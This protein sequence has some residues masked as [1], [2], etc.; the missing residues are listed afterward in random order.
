[1]DKIINKLLVFLLLMA[2]ATPIFSQDSRSYVKQC[3]K[4]HGQCKAVAIT[5]NFGDVVLYGKNGWACKN[6]PVEL[7]DALK[8]LSER[9]STINDVQLTEKGH[10]LVIFD[11]NGYKHSAG[12]PTAFISKLREFNLNHETIISA[13]FNDEGEWAAITQ[14]HLSAS[15][16][17]LLSWLQDGISSYGRIIS[18]TIVDNAVVAVY[19]GGF[20]FLGSV[21]QT[22]KNAL[23][24][25]GMS[26]VNVRISG[27]HWFFV[28]KDGKF[29]YFM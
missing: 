29:Q 5:Q 8:Q 2:V 15:S 13:P 23:K 22:L 6:C 20:K 24:Q 28:S 16:P 26:V 4:Q 25:S 19:S 9:G 7:R 18:A 21:P 1:M 27:E 11:G 10:W 3:I 12:L 17:N 14:Q